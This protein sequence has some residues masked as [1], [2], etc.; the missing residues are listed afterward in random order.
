MEEGVLAASGASFDLRERAGLKLVTGKRT[1][2]F[3]NSAALRNGEKGNSC[4][5]K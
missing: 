4:E 1:V 2:Y 5:R 3:Y